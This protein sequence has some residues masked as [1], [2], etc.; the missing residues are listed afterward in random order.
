MS[1]RLAP[2][3]RLLQAGILGPVAFVAVFLYEDMTRAGYDAR[4]H[5][6]SLLSLGNDGWQQAASFIATG[7]LVAAFAVGLGRSWRSGIGSRWAPRLIAIVGIALVFDGLFPTEPEYGFP[8]GTPEGLPT[9]ITWHGAIHYVAGAVAFVGLAAACLIV[10]VRARNDGQR[11]LAMLS[12]VS[13]V[14]M[15]GV[16]LLS[17]AI[18]AVGGP[19]VGGGLRR[20]RGGG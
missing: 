19:A 11:R 7:L 2:T 1:M 20:R 14:V 18:A 15:L 9:A 13:P 17:Y 6:V 12:A 4:R 8:P 16:W 3:R 5:F 10:A